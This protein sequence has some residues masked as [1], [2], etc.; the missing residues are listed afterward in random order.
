MALVLAADLG[1]TTIT[2]VALDTATGELP[3]CHTLPNRAESTA[4]ADRIKGRSEWDARAIAETA[5]A[6]LRSVAE[7]L[8]PRR[9]EVAGI[10]ITGQ[11]HGVVLVGRDCQP[12]GP[13]VNW[14]DRR[15]EDTAPGTGQTFV[16][17]AL[18][19]MGEDAP[20]RTG[21]RLATGY[22][23]VTLFWMQQTGTLPQSALALALMDYF[24]AFLSG[25]PPVTDATCAAG[26]G[27]LNL[28]GR[29]WDAES[30]AALGLPAALLPPVRPSG[31]RLGGLTPA[32]AAALGLPAGLPVCSG[33]GDNQASYLGSVADRQTT[34]L[35]NVGTGSQVTAYSPAFVYDP[36][37]ETR[38]YPDEGYLLVAAGLCGG[39]SYALLEQ[40]Y[41]QVGA[42]LFGL[43]PGG[44][45]FAAMNRLAAE[46]PA[47]ADGL[48]CEPYFSGSR[49][50]PDLRASWTGMSAENFRPAHLTRAL[51]EG[52]A[53]AFRSGYELVAR[54]RQLGRLVGAGNGLRENPL[55]C[56]LVADEF[57][58]P[59]ALPRHHEEAA[60]GAALLAAVRCGVFSDLTAAGQLL[61][62]VGPG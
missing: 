7:Q 29:D 59:L 18:A 14:Q 25:Q 1:T 53:R 16:Q 49:D 43:P 10:G 44:S 47:G 40:F 23:G 26:S 52:M 17:Q 15:G 35:V 45:L 5:C 34:V 42:R 54:G 22:L 3:A 58:L 9:R 2:A 61:G 13:L 12:L 27:L 60:C 62:H 57:G 41:R 19:R 38:P 51:L 30:L 55:L 39:R 28:H 37:L 6:C 11:Q 33:I 24:G 32:V 50:R 56:R 4:A 31:E 8:G 20:R 48:R 36:R 46:A 21:C